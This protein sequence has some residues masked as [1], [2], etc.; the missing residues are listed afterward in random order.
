[1]AYG[2]QI[3]KF[4]GVRIYISKDNNLKVRSVAKI[5][6]YSWNN[7]VASNPG[8]GTMNLEIR[9]LCSPRTGRGGYDSISFAAI[10]GAADGSSN[11]SKGNMLKCGRVI[12][13]PK[14]EKSED[15]EHRYTTI[16]VELTDVMRNN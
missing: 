16:L 7:R 13:D 9:A 10:P 2:G 8:Y 3:G 14:M 12:E 6:Y 1:M 5:C 15:K 4:D 11:I